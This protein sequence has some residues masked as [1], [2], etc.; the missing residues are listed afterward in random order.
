MPGSPAGEPGHEEELRCAVGGDLG[1]GRVHEKGQEETRGGWM[2]EG[3][4]I[5]G[6]LLSLANG[7]GFGNNGGLGRLQELN[8]LR[9]S[10][11]DFSASG[12]GVAGFCIASPSWLAST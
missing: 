9:E 10:L 3:C 6:I 12:G 7:G 5:R 8:L 11:T 1:V 2:G 4:A